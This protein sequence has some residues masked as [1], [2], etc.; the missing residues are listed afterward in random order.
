MLQG[1][2]QASIEIEEGINQN[3]IIERLQAVVDEAEAEK[4]A[5][6]EAAKQR[7]KDQRAA[8]PAKVK[9]STSATETG[10]FAL[11]ALD[12]QS[13]IFE[14]LDLQ[15]R[16]TVATTVCKCWR[17]LRSIPELWGTIE[18]VHDYNQQRCFWPSAPGFQRLMKMLPCASVHDLSITEL[19]TTGYLHSNGKMLRRVRSTFVKLPALTRLTLRGKRLEDALRYKCFR[20]L[21]Q[22]AGKDHLEPITEQTIKK[23]VL[24]TAAAQPFAQQLTHLELRSSTSLDAEVLAHALRRMPKL[25]SLVTC[26]DACSRDD[27][28]ERLEIWCEALAAANQG[29]ARLEILH[30]CGPDAQHDDVQTRGGPLPWEF[31]MQLGEKL[32]CLL[33]LCGSI[34]IAST[35]F[36]AEMLSHTRSTT[37][38]PA[39]LLRRLALHMFWPQYTRGFYGKPKPNWAEKATTP[40]DH[41]SGNICWLFNRLLRAAS[42][43]E[44]LELCVRKDY[45]ETVEFDHDH[46]TMP[47]RYPPPP[48]SMWVG[49]EGFA[50]P[51]G[52]ACATLQQLKLS[53][54]E[55]DATACRCA[56]PRLRELRIEKLRMTEGRGKA[57][58]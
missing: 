10:P 47:R 57:Y 58:L 51:L 29:S 33:E 21:S 6:K 37:A 18:F 12:L 26:L 3:A 7:A 40:V 15:A 56:L 48:E 9:V 54:F 31:L 22:R 1:D 44:A 46:K 43:L 4:R 13:A 35:E 55:I 38:L 36:Q 23:S 41:T 8:R 52:A 14:L 28:K 32:P 49:V 11:L 16:L 24:L 20:S 30:L 17:A 27:A 42:S 25:T 34:D 5:N 19:S 39:L 50:E 53:G 2:W 45:D